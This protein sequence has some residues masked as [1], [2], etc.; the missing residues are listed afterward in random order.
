MAYFIELTKTDGPIWINV[1]LIVFVQK[2]DGRTYL[3][4]VGGNVADGPVKISVLEDPHE[5]LA[6]ISPN[7]K[8]P[9][10]D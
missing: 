6:L 2:T 4:C 8:E 5:V 7:R 10:E 3:T 9:S 1:D